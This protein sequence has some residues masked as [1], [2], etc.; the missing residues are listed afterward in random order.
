MK[1][2]FDDLIENRARPMS[3]ARCPYDGQEMRQMVAAAVSQVADEERLRF[4]R[5][6]VRRYSM[7]VLLLLLM[8]FGSVKT[9]F[10]KP[11]LQGSISSITVRHDAV[12]AIDMFINHHNM[13]A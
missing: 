13:C 3:S 6:V 4:H 12:A 2:R 9:M 8:M 10:G 11:V 7:S 1:T 5:R